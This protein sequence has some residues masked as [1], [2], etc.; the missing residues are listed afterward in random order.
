MPNR[1]C[2]VILPYPAVPWKLEKQGRNADGDEARGGAFRR[3]LLIGGQRVP[4]NAVGFRDGRSI[5]TEV[6][7][8]GTM[9]DQI[10][11]HSGEVLAPVEVRIGEVFP[12]VLGSTAGLVEI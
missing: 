6:H 8:V 2:R 4:A 7:A 12:S 1:R 11:L 5:V 9:V 3:H 10:R